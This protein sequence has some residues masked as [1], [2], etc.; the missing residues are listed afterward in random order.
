MDDRRK[1]KRF[2]VQLSA[3]YLGENGKKWKE[4]SVI[5]ISREGMG[6][7]VYM[8]EKIHVGSI[9]Q[10]EIDVPVKN[11]QISVM[12]TLMW[13]KKLK[14]NPMFN[15]VGGVM[16]ITIDPEDKWTLLGYA[17]EGWHRKGGEVE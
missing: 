16:L 11:K 1:Y 7:E 5:N 12:G 3:Q 10:L 14:G 9:L 17:Y 13:I 15:F 8:R 6:I 4:C 2:P